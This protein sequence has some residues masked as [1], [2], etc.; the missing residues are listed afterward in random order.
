MIENENDILPLSLTGVVVSKNASS[1]VAVFKIKE[2]GKI[3]IMKVGDSILDMELTHVFQDGIILQKGEK[4]YWLLLE[5]SLQ[6]KTEKDIKKSSRRIEKTD[7]EIDKLKS[8]PL[9]NSL[10]ERE[11]LRSEV[12]ERIERE[13]ALIINETR[14]V[15]NYVDGKIDG[16]KVIDLPKTGI[17]SEV[18]IQ[19]DD[20]I[21]E[22]NGVK[23]DNLSALVT[24][25]GKI[26]E[27][28]RY[29]VL[30]ERNKK[31]FRQVYILK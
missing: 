25:Y 23:L 6:S 22:I 20:V 9:N 4:I 14:V 30:I 15:P 11:F 24:L 10:P 1:S 2:S 21:K 28:G 17:A 8:V 3:V 13:R 16:F 31:L 27:E 12:L 18:G 19:K 26:S 7:Y 5:K 29:E